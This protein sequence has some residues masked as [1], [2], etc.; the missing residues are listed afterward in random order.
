MATF[1]LFQEYMT[2][3]SWVKK[4]TVAE[5]CRGTRLVGICVCVCVR[6][7]CLGGGGGLA[8]NVNNLPSERVEAERISTA[9]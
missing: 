8:F 2:Q 1:G 5:I 6:V 4:T 3:C 9:M 7:L